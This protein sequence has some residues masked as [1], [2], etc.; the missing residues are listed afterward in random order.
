MFVVGLVVAGL[1]AA[2]WALGKLG[3]ARLPGDFSFGGKGWRV[4]LPIGTCVLVSI[5]LSLLLWVVTR[6]RR[7]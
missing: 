6:F 4:Y 1:G 7:G 2:L 5:L 3:L